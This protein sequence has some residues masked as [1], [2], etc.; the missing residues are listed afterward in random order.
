MQVLLGHAA[1]IPSLLEAMEEGRTNLQDF[2]TGFLETLARL[3]DWED[4]F[5]RDGTPC[6]QINPAELDLATGK[7]RLPN[8]CFNFVDVSHAN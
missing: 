7:E 5:A 3:Q 6:Q 4:D 8:P 2:R 1:T